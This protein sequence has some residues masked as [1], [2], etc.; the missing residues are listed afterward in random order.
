MEF[1]DWIIM[2][3]PILLNGICLF[4]FQQI[5]QHKFSKMEKKTEYRQVVLREFLQMLKAFYEKFW[6]IRNSNQK[7]MYGDFDFSNSWNAATGQIQDVIMYY[8]T[9]KAAL[10]I[11]EEFYEKCIHQYQILI[12]VLKEGAIQYKGGYQLTK[13]CR[14]DFSDE[15]WKMDTLIKDCLKQCEQQILKFK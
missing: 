5:I 14:K 1:K 7:E 13:K 11:V 9:H 6:T 2:L 3:V 10:C 4:I 12:D 15:Y 8:D